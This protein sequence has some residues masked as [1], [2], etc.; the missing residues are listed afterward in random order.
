MLTILI[1][2]LVASGIL[3]ALGLRANAG[4]NRRVRAS[5]ADLSAQRDLAATEQVQ[6]QATLS[7][8]QS[9]EYAQVYRR[10]ELRRTELGEVSVVVERVAP[11]PQPDPVSTPQPDPGLYALPWQ[12]WWSVLFD[13]PAP[14]GR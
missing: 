5:E 3:V 13:A 2:V 14:S 4:N 7:Y 1:A 8:V 9:A 6:L 12:M 10:N 11:P